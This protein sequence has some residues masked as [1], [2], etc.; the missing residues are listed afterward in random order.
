MGSCLLLVKLLDVGRAQPGTFGKGFANEVLYTFF[1][2][3]QFGR[4]RSS[5]HML[6]YIT[7]QVW[8]SKLSKRAGKKK[9]WEAH[10]NFCGAVSSFHQLSLLR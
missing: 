3:K 7:F 4:F 2:L 8:A 1:A 10:G 9:T 5:L 6:G